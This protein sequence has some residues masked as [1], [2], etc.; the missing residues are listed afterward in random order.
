MDPKAKKILMNTFWT[1]AGWKANPDAFAGENFDYAKSKGLMFDPVTITH[2]EIIHRLHELHQ[3]ITK[4]RVAAAFLHSLSTKKVHLRSALSSWALTSGLPVHSYEQRSS[5][6][7]NY[8]SCGDCNFHRIM[9]DR[10]YI[11]NDLNVL[12]FER[13]KWGGIRLNFLIY[14]RLDLELFSKQ[15]DPFEV[16]TEDAAILSGM[17]EAIQ[18]CADHESARMLEKRWK[19]VVP[20]SKHERDVL[21]EIWG[22]AGLLVPRDTPRKGRGGSSDFRSMAEWQGDDGYSQEALEFYFGAFL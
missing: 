14:C 9:S 22:Y 6:R 7:P 11:N 13:V 20:S 4:E 8:S 1:S 19:D 10:E 5:V 17:L 21:M 18:N 3:M 2:D 12:N 15:E 16:T